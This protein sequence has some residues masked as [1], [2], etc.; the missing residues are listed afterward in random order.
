MI[1]KNLWIVALLAVT[2]FLFMGCPDNNGDFKADFAKPAGPS[3]D[4][5]YVITDADEIGALLS[6][7]GWNN[8]AGAEVSTDKNV[9]IFN[10]TG[11][12][13]NQGFEL[14]FPEEVIGISYKTLDVTFKLI[15]VTTLTGTGNAKIGF[16]DSVNP[17]N[18]VVPYDKHEIVFGTAA[19]V[20]KT[21]KFT[22]DKPNKLPNDV[23]YFSHNQYGDGASAGSKPPVAYKLEITKIVFGA[24]AV[25]PCCED[26][27]VDACGDCF[28]GLCKDK[29]DDE[30]CIIPV[31]KVTGGIAVHSNFA[32][33]L[34][35]DNSGTFV[36]APAV[37]KTVVNTAT[38]V[39][40][41]E[42]AGAVMYKFPSG[43]TWTDT[44][45]K[46]NSTF[47]YKDY[48]YV[49]V[50][51]EVSNIDAGGG[52]IDLGFKQYGAWQAY[53]N[54][55]E[56]N[57]LSST[58]FSPDGLKDGKYK[59]KFSLQT[60]AGDM[61]SGGFSLQYDQM[62]YSGGATPAAKYDFKIVSVTYRKGA[63][64]TITFNSMGGSAASSMTILDGNAMGADMPRP[65]KP[66]DTFYSWHTKTDL[67]SPVSATTRF[68]DSV[69]LYAE[70]FG[71]VPVAFKI[72][73]AKDAASY[74]A[75]NSQVSSGVS[76]I[77][78]GIIGGS[79]L[80]VS[81]SSGNYEIANTGT[82]GVS[83]ANIIA[84]AKILDPSLNPKTIPALYK[85][86]TIVIELKTVTNTAANAGGNLKNNN[87][88]GGDYGPPTAAQAE[89][90][91]VGQYPAMNAV[92]TI[93]WNFPMSRLDLSDPVKAGFMVQGNNNPN[94]VMVIKSVEFHNRL[95]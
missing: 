38:G 37:G 40:T 20:E 66:G 56:W 65:T 68:Y 79:A 21:Q 67:A 15:E 3:A 62:N 90:G 27:D 46:T 73:S 14:K 49:D 71:G 48:D 1:K 89:A 42:T 24:T 34:K 11:S 10:I 78:Q 8:N 43:T 22:L 88:W 19:G 91:A 44:D 72:D 85:C 52:N 93:T 39:A 36:N 81:G 45:K 6:K 12:T 35:A 25:V 84:A 29:C 28:N 5:D 32:A 94:Y 60:W 7:K 55:S 13:D 57:N 31:V 17:T 64:H 87:N 9:A 58:D 53:G 92:G 76:N 63:R 4:K 26:C 80:V 54:T 77:N 95:F 59:G 51:F 47:S 70:W 61:G 82:F 75:L 18:D 23:L 74:D 30:C 16:K 83:F 69:T 2:A 33:N 50:E 41:F 86:F